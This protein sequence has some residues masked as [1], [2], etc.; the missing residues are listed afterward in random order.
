[1]TRVDIK[2]YLFGGLTS[3]SLKRHK[4]MKEDTSFSAAIVMRRD[5][6]VFCFWTAGAS[7]IRDE[8]SSYEKRQ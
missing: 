3:I 4:M 1:M 8:T 5:K 2:Y 6:G 7:I